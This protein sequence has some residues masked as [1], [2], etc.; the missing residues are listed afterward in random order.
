MRLVRFFG[1]SI[2]TFIIVLT[3]VRG[4]CQHTPASARP[5]LV[6]A[7]IA[8]YAAIADRD[9]S[10]VR[11]GLADDFRWVLATGGQVV[12]RSELIAAIAR[13]PSSAVVTYGVDSAHVEIVG[14]VAMVDYRLTDRRRFGG[15]A[16]AFVSR[17]TDTFIER[18]GEWR[19]TRRTQTWIVSPPATITLGPTALRAFVGRYEH[20]SG[21]VDDVRLEGGEL[22]ATSSAEAAAALPGA[23]L[24]PVS[25]DA[26]S[27]DGV[28]PLIVFER[29]ASGRVT[30][31]VQQSPDG[32]VVRA[33]R[34]P[35]V[36]DAGDGEASPGRAPYPPRSPHPSR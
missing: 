5:D 22:V 8:N 27:P 12:T 24:R 16:R 7:I 10:A 28:A 11:G 2:A 31:Y 18:D 15:Y 30:G 33:R 9:T 23:H 6:A 17:G 19:L 3:P 25:D 32:S 35:A 29:D 13:A 20:G 21:F 1:T 26:F 36:S 4:W 34:L 14:R